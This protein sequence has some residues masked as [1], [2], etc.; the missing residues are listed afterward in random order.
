[1]ALATIIKGDDNSGALV[2]QTIDCKSAGNP[3]MVETSYNEAEE[4]FFKANGINVHPSVLKPY[5]DPNF[6]PR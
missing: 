3:Y 4:Q 6:N 2:N 1:M 5:E